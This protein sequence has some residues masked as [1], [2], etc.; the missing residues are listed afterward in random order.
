[1]HLLGGNIFNE[2]IEHFRNTNI[3]LIKSFVE[4]SIKREDFKFKKE[5]SIKTIFNHLNNKYNIKTWI[6]TKNNFNLYKS[7]TGDYPDINKYK[8][9]SNSIFHKRRKLNRPSPYIKFS[10]K[11]KNGTFGDFNMYL[12]KSPHNIFT[13]EFISGLIILILILAILLWPFS[14]YITKPIKNFTLSALHITDGNLSERVIISSSDEIGELGIAFN[15]MADKNELMITG[16]KELTANI[17]H[18]LRSPLA[19]VRVAEELLLKKMTPMEKKNY[20]HLLNSIEIEIKEMDKLIGQIL[21]L[22]KLDTTNNTSA[23]E[24]I[25]LIQLFYEIISKFPEESKLNKI[26]ISQTGKQP[27]KINANKDDIKIALSNLI[28]NAIKY[29][30]ENENINIDIDKNLEKKTIRISIS[31]NSESM[32]SEDLTKIFDPFFRIHKDERNGS[33]LGLAIT[34]KSIENQNGKILAEYKDGVF[35]IKIEFLSEGEIT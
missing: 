32:E 19:R 24:S 27:F 18:E 7:F 30:L 22:T 13:K 21:L 12:G 9:K 5:N 2:R 14:R 26:N 8:K 29:T 1:M 3:Y 25:D 15:T 31:N 4:D 20:S 6:T 16:T 33:G 11:L 35:N 28:D 17:S 34:K 23:K 10:I